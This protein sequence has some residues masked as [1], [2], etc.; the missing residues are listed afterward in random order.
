MV[1]VWTYVKTG[2]E[3][4]T[5]N[6]NHVCF[7][8]KD[9]LCEGIDYDSPEEIS[10][11]VRFWVTMKSPSS[12]AGASVY[13][14]DTEVLLILSSMSLWPS[15]SYNNFPACQISGTTGGTTI[16]PLSCMPIKI[17]HDAL[18]VSETL[19]VLLNICGSMLWYHEILSHY[20]SIK[21]FIRHIHI[22]HH[23]T[24]WTQKNI[25]G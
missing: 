24:L 3:P 19:H 7:C 21:H 8:L 9:S 23:M 13:P 16:T 11:C 4:S 25:V 5:E 18:C 20:C 15:T 17:K 12:S 14:C 1:S 6:I 2:I 10:G 22:S